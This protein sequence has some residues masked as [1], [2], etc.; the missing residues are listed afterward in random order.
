M[1]ASRS[2]VRYKL[3]EPVNA[4]KLEEHPG[5]TLR[6]P[7]E[8]LVEIPASAVVELEGVAAPSGLIN[9][10]WDGNAFSVFYD[11]LKEKAQL[12]GVAGT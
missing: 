11:D 10:L 8:T 1:Q 2:P 4:V 9:I 5:S 7:T 3:S 12:L 6:N